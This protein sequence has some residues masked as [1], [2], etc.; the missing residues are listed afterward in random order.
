MLK[1]SL[2]LFC[3]CLI[4][5]LGLNGF[6]SAQ[7]EITVKIDGRAVAFQDQGPVLMN[8][9]TMVPMGKIFEVLGAT[10]KW[11]ASTS[12][13]TAVKGAITVSLKIGSTTAN[14][15]GQE[16]IMDVPAQILNGRTMVPLGFVSEA[17]GATVKW[18]G[19]TRTVSISTKSNAIEEQKSPDSS[20]HDPKSGE[21]KN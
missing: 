7:G 16:I 8:N 20:E 12:T 17:M 18:D 14:K 10:V 19:S 11:K 4:L 21:N 13:V 1:K 6:A 3:V 15:N 5:T 2:V 9:R